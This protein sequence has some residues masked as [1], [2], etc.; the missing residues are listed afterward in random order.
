MSFFGK[1]KG[2]LGKKKPEHTDRVTRAAASSSAARVSYN[3]DVVL[4]ELLEDTKP[5]WEMTFPCNDFLEAAG[6]KEEFDNL[7]ANA[8]LTR[9][10]TCCV[11][12]YRKLT[13]CFINSFGYNHDAG[14]IEFKIYDDP[15]TMPLERFCEIIGV[16]NVRRTKKMNTQPTKLRM[17]FNS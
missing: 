15:L 11:T 9:L 3:E 4:M 8:G 7:C 10:A 16:S 17:L 13:S 12:Q 14:L 2:W 5:K 6:I 1:A